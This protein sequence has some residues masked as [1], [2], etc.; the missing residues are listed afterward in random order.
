MKS[1]EELADT[2]TAL[3]PEIIPEIWSA[4]LEKAANAKRI[5]RN[6]IRTYTTLRDGPG[7]ILRVPKQGKIDAVGLTEGTDITPTALDYGELVLT[8][9]EVGAAVR[10]TKDVVE[11]S[12]I[13]V[14]RD[15]TE[16]LGEALA[17]KEDRDILADLAG[18]T[19]HILY[20]G[21]ASSAATLVQ[22]DVL[23]TD[24][25]A[26]GVALIREDNFEPDCFVIHPIQERILLKDAQFT[27]ASQYGS[28][29]PV[30]KGEIGKYLGL[31]V[32]V[33]TNVQNPA[34]DVHS[35]VLMDAKRAGA[36]AVKRDAT[37]DTDYEVLKRSHLIVGT[38][39]YDA[40]V[41]NDLAICAIVV[42]DKE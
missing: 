34:V 37:V 22:G 27:D 11:N 23:T 19:G 36:I 41:L 3:V 6:L 26:S 13:D 1:L 16:Q 38:M 17:Q 9:A 12:I 18:P 21:D 15:A 28:Q 5:A 31:K 24:M 40:G 8:P 33:S 29:E 25:I 10:V 32:I 14:L 2:T 20:G 39:K 42:H 30:L 35:C 7:D 4:E